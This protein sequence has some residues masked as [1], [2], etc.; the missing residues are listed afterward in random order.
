MGRPPEDELDVIIRPGDP[1]FAIEREAWTAAARKAQSLHSADGLLAGVADDDWHVRYESIDRLKA[2]RHDDD[3]TFPALAKL[4][5]R[6]PKRHVR[7]KALTAL[8]D[9]DRDEV[10][11]I[12]ERAMQDPS[13][14]VGWDANFVLYQLGLAKSLPDYPN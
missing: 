2:R 6:D 10:A 8:L 13:S 4:A 11:S 3:R 1:R 9:F 7:G 14:H 12:A 5:E